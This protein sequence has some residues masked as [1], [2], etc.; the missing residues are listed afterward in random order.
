MTEKQ[1]LGRL[2]GVNLRDYWERED[3]EFTPWLAQEENIVLLGDTIGLELEVQEQEASV[4]PFRADILC[5][6]AGDNSLV[7]IENQLEVTDHKHLGQLF[8]YAAGLDAV[9]VIWIAKQFTEEHRAALDWLNRITHDHFHFFGVEIE[10]YRINTS[11]PAPRFSIVSKPNDWVKSATESIRNPGA[12]T[13]GQK[14]Q[15]GY[16]KALGEYMRAQDSPRKPPTPYPSNW[17]GYGIGRVGFGLLIFINIRDGRVVVGLFVDGQ[18]AIAHYHLLQA[19]QAAIESELG[20]TLE[21]EEKPGAKNSSITIRL[22]GDTRDE[23]Q[24]P[25]FFEWTLEKMNDFDRVFRSRIK[26]LDASQWQGSEP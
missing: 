7:L 25:Q 14:L 22:D 1:P 5:R 3:T 26:E 24:W 9:T 23:S 20:Y 21:W 12:Y 4:G 16:W 6:N 2:E 18:D 8:T 10:L 11:P 17:M 13:P 19:E 15:M